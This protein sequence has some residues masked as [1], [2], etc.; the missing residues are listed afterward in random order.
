MADAGLAYECL[1]AGDARR[2][3]VKRRTSLKAGHYKGQV[4]SGTESYDAVVRQRRRCGYGTL[5]ATSCQF[6][7]S[8]NISPVPFTKA[9]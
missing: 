8:V 5:L 7:V 1:T 6:V 4:V 9:P 3:P 2:S